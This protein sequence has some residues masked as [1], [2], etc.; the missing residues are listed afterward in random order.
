[1]KISIFILSVFLSGCVVTQWDGF[2][3]AKT[4]EIFVS[5][6][7]IPVKGVTSFCKPQGNVLYIEEEISKELNQSAKPT[8]ESGKIN[9]SYNGFRIGGSFN[10]FLGF[11]W[12]YTPS[13][14]VE[15]SLFYN[16][17][18]INTFEALSSNKLFEV[19]VQ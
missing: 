12:G 7:E 16:G 1:M 2:E 9:M 10:S 19:K 5:K 4:F 6:N 3:E 8:D 15:C 11:D 14:K 18:K 13:P 17:N